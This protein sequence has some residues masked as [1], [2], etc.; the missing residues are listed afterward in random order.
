MKF[1]GLFRLRGVGEGVELAE[2]KLILYQI[3]STPSHFPSIQTH[4][5]LVP[6]HSF[7]EI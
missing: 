5:K 2:N 6:I 4:H 1:K 7:V 3:Y